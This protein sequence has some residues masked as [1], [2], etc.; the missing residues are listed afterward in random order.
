MFY[1]LLKVETYQPQQKSISF[2]L[3]SA[4][5][6]TLLVDARGYVGEPEK[7]PTYVVPDLTEGILKYY[8]PAFLD[9]PC[10]IFEFRSYFESS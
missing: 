6:D 4:G 9:F 7:L 10:I 5:S 3:S 8:V 1:A 2:G